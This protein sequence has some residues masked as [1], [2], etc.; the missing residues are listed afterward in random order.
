MD[1]EQTKRPQP[2]PPTGTDALR[3]TVDLP[4]ARRVAPMVPGAALN[5]L[6]PLS[7]AMSTRVQRSA[8][9]GGGSTPSATDDVIRRQVD[10]YNAPEDNGYYGVDVQ[11]IKNLYSQLVLQI[12]VRP[13]NIRARK[14]NLGAEGGIDVSGNNELNIAEVLDP[15]LANWE[16]D[17]K[18]PLFDRLDTHAESL[19]TGGYLS[20]NEHDKLGGA[21]ITMAA[22]LLKIG[23]EYNRLETKVT[24]AG[25]VSPAKLR[26]ELSESTDVDLGNLQDPYSIEKD[27]K[28][29]P[30]DAG[31]FTKL[32]KGELT[33]RHLTGVEYNRPLHEHIGGGNDGISFY[34]Y[35]SKAGKVH[36]IVYDVSNGREGNTYRWKKGTS[37]SGP[38]DHFKKLR[39]DWESKLG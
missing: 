34:Y 28:V 31:L 18:G 5:A 10:L 35:A 39:A 30:E 7:R 12:R 8:L 25:A 6:A 26:E 13:S 19:G 3:P 29:L 11:D 2:A 4:P 14:S 22:A 20:L 24:G 36:P 32:K 9:A 15:T 27:K 16:K 23:D 33:D 21:I 1:F 38:S 37:S 17:F